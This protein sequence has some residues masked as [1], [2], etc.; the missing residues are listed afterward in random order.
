[1]VG[2]SLLVS[3]VALLACTPRP[4]EVTFTPEPCPVVECPVSGTEYVFVKSSMCTKAEKVLQTRNRNIEQ[5]MDECVAK[6][7][8]YVD[9][10][11]WV[12]GEPKEDLPEPE[13]P[14][15]P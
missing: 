5:R 6:A 4:V 2:R 14:V 13:D 1:M 3:L 15:E 9:C 12:F 8:E 10:L 11:R 7:N